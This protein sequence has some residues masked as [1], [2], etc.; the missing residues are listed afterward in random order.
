MLDY[1]IYYITVCLL[2]V[3][4]VYGFKCI[5]EHKDRIHWKYLFLI[6]ITSSIMTLSFYY[7]LNAVTSII[8]MLSY[9]IL[10]Y[11]IFRRNVK[12]TIFYG[13]SIWII[14]M[15]IDFIAMICSQIFA[16]LPLHIVRASYTIIMELI[17][18]L[19]FRIK[20]LHIILKSFYDKIKQV[21]F[22]YLEIILLIVV[23][24]SMSYTLYFLV[25]ENSIESSKS[26]L[27]I[28][29][30]AVLILIF[31]YVNREFN[32]YALKQTNE[33]L[34]KNNEFYINIVNDYRILKHNII[35][36]LSGIKSVSNEKTIKLID[37]LIE[38]Y[39]NK[40]VNVQ[41]MKKM[42]VGISG[43]VYEKIYNFNDKELRLGIDN[44]IESNIFDNLTPR[45]YN[46][47]CEAL[48][49]LLDNALQATEKTKEKIIMIDMKETDLSYNI[50]IINTFQDLLDIEQL[51]S[52][53]YTTKNTGHGI[54]LFYLIGRKKLK[55]KTSIIN[56]LF[57]SEITI[58]KKI[59]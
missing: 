37:D 15:I 41:H 19:V 13:I 9:F 29:V 1:V 16:F 46:L 22:P 48:G 40:S 8:S 2:Q 34:I 36:Q 57:I 53:K 5:T 35:H 6:F 32:N 11:L 17:F 24:L 58:E 20:K 30:P 52:V 10:Y 55:V 12:E 56:D 51:G 27:L 25:I 43:I 18:L 59:N 50:K 28:L 47:L 44:N 4:L 14:G 54:G 26:S 3:T 21:K 7:N 49:I 38:Q 31:I 39:N 23:T 42:P 45:S 33:Y